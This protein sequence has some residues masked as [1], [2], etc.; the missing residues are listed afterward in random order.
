MH[1]IE[2]YV[3]QFKKEFVIRTSPSLKDLENIILHKLYYRLLPYQDNEELF[4]SL[5]KNQNVKCNFAVAIRSGDC[6]HI[7]YNDNIPPADRPF[8]FAH[9]I[10]HIYLGHYSRDCG[11]LDTHFRKEQEANEFATLL[12]RKPKRRIFTYIAHAIL[13]AL[14]YLQLTSP[15]IFKVAGDTFVSALSQSPAH[16]SVVVTREGSRYHKKDCGHIKNRNTLQVFSVDKAKSYGY[17][18]CLDCF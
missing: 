10:A 3:T 8:I 2:K 14:I 9:E 15:Q 16:S 18:P 17:T 4:S 5:T 11:Y 12:L 1:N 13:L 6:R 7:F